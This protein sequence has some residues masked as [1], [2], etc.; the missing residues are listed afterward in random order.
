MSRY[1][2]I[3]FGM[4]GLITLT[5]AVW[6]KDGRRRG[7]MAAMGGAMML[8]YSISIHDPIFIALQAVFIVSSLVEVRRPPAKK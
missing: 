1:L 5:G 3:F 7:I 6:I 4:V 8:V 2:I